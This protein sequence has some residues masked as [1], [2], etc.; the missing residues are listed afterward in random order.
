MTSAPKASASTLFPSTTWHSARI[1][2]GRG[3]ASSAAS[4]SAFTASN[5]STLIGAAVGSCSGTSDSS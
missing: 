5:A 3:V 2:S 1:G 4:R